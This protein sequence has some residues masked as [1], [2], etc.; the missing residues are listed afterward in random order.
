MIR[1]MIEEISRDSIV[2]HYGMKQEDYDEKVIEV[3]GD[4][5]RTKLKCDILDK[6]FPT[7]D[8][9]GRLKVLVFN[10]AMDNLRRMNGMK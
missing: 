1:D 6:H 3:M 2:S 8:G 10:Q 4:F 5:M 7:L 9:E